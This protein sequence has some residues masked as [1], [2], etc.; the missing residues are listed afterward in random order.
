MKKLLAMLLALTMLLGMTGTFASAEEVVTLK[1]VTVGS[2]MPTN[3]DAW[4]AQINPYL[5]EKIGVNV[6]V[7][8]IGWGDWDNRR[9]MIIS[10]NEPYDIIFGNSGTYNNDVQM[11]AYYEI[12]EEMLA[13]YA[14]GLMEL[15]PSAYWDACRVDGLIYAVPTYKDSSMTNYFVWDKELLDANGLDA[16]EGHTL[17]AIEP[18]LY[19][20]KDKTSNTVYPLNSNGAT[21]LLSVYDQMST[22]LPAIGVRIDDTEYKVVATLEQEDIMTSLSLLHKWY[23]DG[24]INA[25]A[26]THAES[27]KYNVCSVAQG[28][29][30]AAI[31]TWGPNM[32]VEAVAYQFGQTIASNETVQ[33]SLNSI[34][35]NCPYP[36]KALQLLDII[37][38]DTY[39]RDLFY[40]GVEGE[41]WEYTEDG[42]VHK[43]NAEWTMAGYTQATFFNVSLT[44]DM[45]F[46]QWDEVRELN[47]NA[48]ASV[49]LGFF[50][51]TTPIQDQLAS[52]IEIFNRYK[53]E[54][55]TGTT[56][57][58]V[59]VPQMMEE[60]RAAGF[61]DIVAEA[62]AQVDAFVAAK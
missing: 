23:N 41:N 30:S 7:E 22:G 20:L 48:T 17:E 44:D 62:Q 21:Y 56:D 49:L 58:A 59:S 18:I 11:G 28:W 9:N 54:V 12:T 6:D 19:E 61:D 60:M 36:E 15:I 29:P 33:G 5:A 14:P 37:N 39:V 10:T 43:I 16:S 32:G 26:A 40:Y 50:F 46:N 13:E 3:Y 1:W 47:D 2:G 52:C 38:T 34:S 42:R 24:I 8:V 25:D 53:G 55:L 57:P 45:D 4:L 35:I 31:T 51:D 27:N